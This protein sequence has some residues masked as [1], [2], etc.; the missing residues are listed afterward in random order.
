[1]PI[2][3]GLLRGMLGLLCIF[4][5]HYFG[6][7]WVRF[8]AGRERYSRLIAWGLR[9]AVTVLGLLWPRGLDAVA[10]AFFVLSA[11]AMAAGAYMELRPRHEEDL[12]RTIFPE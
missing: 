3:F 6:R 2:P 1:M 5:A 8:R 4:F 9:T 7:S 11:C 12:T 10:I